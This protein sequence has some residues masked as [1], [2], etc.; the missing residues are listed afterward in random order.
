MKTGT[1]RARKY[2]LINGF[3]IWT[4]L[5]GLPG[6]MEFV[7]FSARF[8]PV[9]PVSVDTLASVRERVL[10]IWSTLGFSLKFVADD[11]VVSYRISTLYP[12]WG[13]KFTRM[14][15]TPSGNF[16]ENTR[17]FRGGVL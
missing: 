11:G 1:I 8:G 7:R 4:R 2:S 13:K 14:G 6:F 9:C 5:N 16:R 3:R 10:S 17:G 15:R 12:R